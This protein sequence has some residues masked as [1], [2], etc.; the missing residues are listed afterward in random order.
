LATTSGKGDVM[1]NMMHEHTHER[2]TFHGMV[3]FGEQTAYLS[4][5]PMFMSPHDYQAIF[6][7]TFSK[8]GSDPMA[9][10]V[11][12][13]RENTGSKMYGFAP[14]I[15]AGDQDP[16][17][18]AFV[19]TDLVT[20]AHPQ[21][22]ASPPLRRA[23]KGDIYRG[24]FET[25]HVHE[26]AASDPPK[27]IPGLERVAARVTNV[28][29]F[30]KF[31]PNPRELPQLEYLLFGKAQELFLAHV[32][33]G[34]P[35]FDQI[36]GVQVEGR[37][38]TDDELRRGIL[39]T[40]PGRENTAERKIDEQEEVTGQVQVPV[41]RPDGP[42]SVAVQLKAGTQFYFETDDLASKM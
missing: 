39:V 30:R 4:H 25:F 41:E 22:P 9:A 5:L 8:E 24:H 37:E 10:Y 28:V 19:L 32:I 27:P 31:D 42:H 23:F 21:D 34:P 6:E 40:F 29:V 3:L 13:R 17:T 12:D 15:D 20:P 18:D 7:V 11:Q 35:D 26:K 16:L 38:F 33:T 36:L 2:P 1:H 14:V